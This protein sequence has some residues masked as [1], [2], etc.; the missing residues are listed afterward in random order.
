MR[1]FIVSKCRSF[2]VRTCEPV[3]TSTVVRIDAHR[4]PRYSRL[5]VAVMAGG[6]TLACEILEWY[7]VRCPV[8]FGEVASMVERVE[9]IAS[10][11]PD[12]VVPAD[13][14]RNTT[15]ALALACA[16]AG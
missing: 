3:E 8:A 1:E 7:G 12:Y 4:R 13:N 6:D 2:N 16:L 11:V 10:A 9:G 15:D 5:T 14:I